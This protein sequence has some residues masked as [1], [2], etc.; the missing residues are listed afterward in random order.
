MPNIYDNLA[1]QT[2]LRPALREALQEYDTFDVATG[3]LD[4]RG[5][6]GLADL[7]EDKSANGAAGPVARIL[8]GMVA[9]SD[10]Q[11][12][13]DSLQHEVQ[14]V[15]YGAEIHDAGKARARRDQLVNHLRNQ[16]MRGLATEQ[17]Q[18]TLQTLKRQ[19]ESGAVQMKVFTEKPLHGK[20]YLFQTPSKK[21]HSRWAFVGSSNLTNAGLTTN[22]ELNIDVQDS[23]ASAKLADWFQ[24]RWDDRYSLEIGSEIIELIAESWAAELQPTP[25]EVYLKV[26]H[27]LSQDARDGLGYV[28][29][30]SMRTLLLDYQESAVRTLAR[31]IVSRGGTM[32]GDVVG[33]GK[34]LTAIATA[35]MLQAAEDYST[36]VLCPKTLEPMWTR[37]IEEYDLNGRVVPYS[38]VDK[39]LPE[40]KRF[41]L[42]ICD[43]SHNLRNSG[44]VA[45]QAIHDYIRRNASKVLLLTATPY[46]LAFLDVAS[47]IGL[48]IDDDQD[49]GIVPSAALVAEPGLR[50][51]VDGK[52]NTLLAFRRSE[53]AEDWRR[54]MSDHLVRRTRSFVKRTAATEVISLPDGTQQERQF[55]QFANGEKF[56]FPQRIARPRSHDFAADDPAALMEDD[57]TLNTV[58]ALT[59]PRYRLADYD[60]PRATHTITDTA[61]LADIRSGRGNVSGFVRTGLFK[62]LSSSGHSFI[63]SLQRQRARNELF[64]HAINEQ[65][66]IPVGSFTDKQFNVTDEDLEEAAVTHGSLTSRYEELR[67]SAPGKTKWINSA[68]FTP[69]LRRDLESDNERISLLLDRFGSW[70]PSRDSKLNALVD[71]LRNEHPGDKVLVF[72]EYVD[73][74]N[75]IAQSLTEAGIA[76]VGLVSG[77]TDN[78]AEMAIRFS[79]QSNTVPGK[80]APD[81]TEADP[82]DVLVATDVLSEGQNL[83]DAHIVVNYDLPWAIIRIIQR[84]GRVDRVGQKSDTVYVYL[85]SHDKIEQQINLRQRIKSRL[86][87]SAEAFGSDEQFFGGPAEIKILDDFYK[88]KVSEDAEDVDG[89]ADA[90]SE[91]WLAWS[92]AQ[93]KHPQIAAK[94]LAMQDLLHSSRDQYLT[95]SR[96]GVACFV[97]TDSGV[98]AFASATL[99]PSGAV[100]HQL[101]TP[102]EAMRMFQAQVDTPTAEVRPDHFELE[103]Q[104]LQGPLT[105]EA[106][107]AGN[108]KGIRKWVWERL[109]GNTLFEQASDA[110]NALQERPLTE[111]ATARL[112]QARR[113]RYSLDDLADLITQLHRDDRLVI[114]S[115]DID[116]IKLVCSIG[117]KDA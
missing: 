16:L 15:P 95:E 37:Y 105:L 102:L 23:D 80:P 114:R 90:V 93:T 51:K 35:L 5:W 42:V 41:N 112:T 14:P 8:V 58:Q 24:A 62:R 115:T 9:P 69:A 57:T 99:D 66:P 54:L 78:P 79:P 56:Y 31:R 92:N 11:Q 108:L 45:Y 109:G 77:N 104:L 87:A 12:I 67:N 60:N 98:E 76:N 81:T 63:L 43:E 91:A 89:E 3:Y 101:L 29:P 46:N 72:T 68:V 13:L 103:R 2:R 18:Q 106:L 34:T 65:L 32:L 70:D 88:G 49:L 74:A 53:H 82:I 4:L 73:T 61:A 20:T 55:L 28:L 1:P 59:L 36:L 19:L 117:V 94:V 107:A 111:H 39:V 44:T 25:F 6:A 27:A 110:L 52:I 21:H 40:M 7:V 26:C 85:I 71:L 113:N 48:Y 100:S 22:L 47:Q 38:M 33:L 96:G 64:I 10:S 75:Y 50:D 97:S 83:Q 116:N 17:G 84:A 86:G 30:E